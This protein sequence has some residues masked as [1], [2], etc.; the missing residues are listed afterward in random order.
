MVIA[1]M[2]VLNNNF[3]VVPGTFHNNSNSSNMQKVSKVKHPKGFDVNVKCRKRMMAETK[4][5]PVS[6][7]AQFSERLASFVL[8]IGVSSSELEQP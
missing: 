7:N 4:Q 6:L 8:S 5:V 3:C 2:S 1:R